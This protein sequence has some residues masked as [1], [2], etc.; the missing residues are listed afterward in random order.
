M[1]PRG[2]YAP[3]MAQRRSDTPLF[4]KALAATVL[5]LLLWAVIGYRNHQAIQ[6]YEQRAGYTAAV[7]GCADDRLELSGDGT[8]TLR[9][10]GGLVMRECT[11]R[12]RDRYLAAE[13]AEQRQV[14]VATLAWGLLPSLLLLLLAAFAPELRRLFPRPPDV[15]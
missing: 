8:T 7:Q 11:E 5:W 4:R 6:P 12:I 10:V 13:N 9:Q 15:R 2:A 1:P 14:A 3:L